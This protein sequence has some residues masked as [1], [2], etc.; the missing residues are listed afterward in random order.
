MVLISE[1]NT[2]YQDNKSWNEMLHRQ[3]DSSVR[4]SRLKCQIS[5]R[6][7]L[8][9]QTGT[10]QRASKL[11]KHFKGELS[12]GRQLLPPIGDQVELLGVGQ[13]HLLCSLPQVRGAVRVSQNQPV[14]S[15]SKNKHT[16]RSSENLS[17]MLVV[18]RVSTN[19]CSQSLLRPGT[20]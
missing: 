19:H 14:W 10:S 4:F 5:K 8:L 9:S 12:P 17:T 1:S 11:P 7:Q 3:M 18:L 16:R 6:I 13:Q 20:T 15:N 2:V